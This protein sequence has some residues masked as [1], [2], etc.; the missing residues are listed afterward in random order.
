MRRS[1]LANLMRPFPE[2]EEPRPEQALQVLGIPFPAWSELA[3]QVFHDFAEAAPYGVSWWA[4]H[5]GTRRRILISDQLFCCLASVSD[6]M[7]EAALHWL[8]YQDASERDSERLVD[9][10]KVTASGVFIDPPRARHVYDQLCPT[11]VRMNLAGMV[12]SLASALDCLAGVITGV[13]ALPLSI[14]KADLKFARA[15]LQRIDATANPG[16]KA[17]AEFGAQLETAIADAGPE[18]WL[19]WTLDLR[20][21]LVH[22]GRRLEIGQYVPRQPIL[23]GPDGQPVPRVRRVARLPRDPGRSDVEVFLSNPQ[24]TILSEETDETLNGL[25]NSTRALLDAIAGP[26]SALWTWRRSNA[27]ALVQPASQWKDGPSSVSTNFKGYKP[28]ATQFQPGLGSVHPDT[29][30][31]IHAAALDDASRPRWS[32]FD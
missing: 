26:L 5:P 14:L 22:R 1:D 3:A 32:A 8:E 24:E 19:D 28:S 13:A 23:L 11:F 4:P 15:A 25:I 21:M 12:R 20:N 18:G 6:N 7:T 27:A 2:D 29:A 9:A 30:R 16:A 17:Q 10:V 31:R